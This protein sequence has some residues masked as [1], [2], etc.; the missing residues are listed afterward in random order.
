MIFGSTSQSGR[1]NTKMMDWGEFTTLWET[2]FKIKIRSFW[3]LLYILYLARRWNIHDFENC[4]K[5]NEFVALSGPKLLVPPSI[6]GRK[7]SFRLRR[8]AQS[9]RRGV[10]KLW[11]F[12]RHFHCK[13]LH[14]GAL[15]KILLTSSLR[16]SEQ[17]I[18]WRSW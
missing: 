8:L 9:L 3:G 5:S 13:F 11:V 7:C 18:L 10:L 14:T 2:C 6:V 1:K 16:G 4:G 15:E 12:G 17:K